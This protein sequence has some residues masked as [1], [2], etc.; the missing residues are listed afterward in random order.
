MQENEKM[1]GLSFDHVK[2]L[3]CPPSPARHLGHLRPP[4]I[5][6]PSKRA[7]PVRPG[8]F[9]PQRRNQTRSTSY[10]NRLSREQRSRLQ[11]LRIQL[12]I[13]LRRTASETARR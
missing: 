6:H 13:L 1:I 7:E 10:R 8:N 5:F 9:S 11:L 2:M 4:S 12:T 3:T